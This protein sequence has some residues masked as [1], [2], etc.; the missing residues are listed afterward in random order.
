MNRYPNSYL[1]PHLEAFAYDLHRLMPWLCLIHIGL[2][3]LSVGC[4]LVNEEIAYCAGSSEA[5]VTTQLQPQ[6]TPQLPRLPQLSSVQHLPPVPQ[7]PSMAQ[8]LQLHEV[9]RVPQGFQIPYPPQTPADYW[10]QLEV[11]RILYNL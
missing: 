6:Q 5:L 4:C 1:Y 10:E 3:Y 11:S 9:P 8:F 7:L 2:V